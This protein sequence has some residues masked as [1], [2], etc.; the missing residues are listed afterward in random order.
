MLNAVGIAFLIVIFVNF[1]LETM[2]SV[3]NLR[4]LKQNAG[5]LPSVLRDQIDLDTY[6][7]SVR[8]NHDSGKFGML[9]TAVSLLLIIY[10]VYWGGFA[11]IDALARTI[12]PGGYY[13]PALIFGVSIFLI[14]LIIDVPFNI[15]NTFVIENRYGFNKTTP[16]VYVADFFKSLIVSAFIGIPL[17]LGVLW[18]MAKAGDYWWLWCWCFI[19]T[20]QALLLIIFPVWIAPLFNKFTPIAEGELKEKILS[21][22]KKAGFPSQGIFIMD[23]SKRSKHSNAYFTGLGKKKRI[24]LFDTLVEQMRLPQILAVLAHEFG[25]FRLHHIKKIFVINSI[26]FLAGLY[27]LSH[28]FRLEIFYHGFG[29]SHPSNY[30]ALIILGLSASS[31][32]FLV[33]PI[34]SM[35]SR[36]FEYQ[37]DEFAIKNL[38]EPQAMPEVIAVLTKE[39]LINVNPH[40]WYSFFHYSHPSP[41]E[42]INALKR[43]LKS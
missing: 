26:V 34:F 15:Y 39:N 2:L 33:T 43:R 13:L 36:R 28:L 20:L 12:D 23:G 10:F 4:Y 41:V 35:I 38:E 32:S 21:L 25:H 9:E 17:Y 24:V 8:Y 3:L 19:E 7:K 5:H 11:R 37:A 30:A 14:K 27:V 18:F 1:F 42:R 22:S 29:F 16:K 6:N 40:P 31:L